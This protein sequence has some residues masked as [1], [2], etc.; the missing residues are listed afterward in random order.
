MGRSGVNYVKQ[1]ADTRTR[2]K[3]KEE[4]E[5]YECSRRETRNHKK[6]KIDKEVGRH[7]NEG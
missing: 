5:G 3:C 7:F 4:K 1:R 6:L 2:W